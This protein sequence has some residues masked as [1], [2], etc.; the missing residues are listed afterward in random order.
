MGAKNWDSLTCDFGIARFI[1]C[2]PLGRMILGQPSGRVALSFSRFHL[3]YSE[4][5]KQYGFPQGDS[6]LQDCP[7]VMR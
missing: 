1:P 5:V 6:D 7:E 4:I 2:W 3:L